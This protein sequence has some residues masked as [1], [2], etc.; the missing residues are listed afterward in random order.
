MPPGPWRPPTLADALEAA[1]TAARERNSARRARRDTLRPEERPPE[2]M[3]LTG[4]PAEREQW[5]EWFD[6]PEPDPHAPV[7]CP[8]LAGHRCGNLVS[9]DRMRDIRGLAEALR[10]RPNGTVVEYCCDGCEDWLYRAGR[11]DRI[12]VRRAQGAPPAW[13]AALQERLDRDRWAHGNPRRP[14]VGVLPVV[15]GARGLTPEDVEVELEAPPGTF[16]AGQGGRR[17][18]PG[19]DPSW[20]AR[21]PARVERALAAAAALE[22]PTFAAATATVPAAVSPTPTPSWWAR[23]VAALARL[24]TG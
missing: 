1:R 3:I 22:L 19:A 2:G 6:D 23:L 7:R 5:P 15:L 17:L 18:A 8:G 13:L 14:N 16:L 9:P 12:A 20:L 24:W 11:A 21:R 4:C 10:R